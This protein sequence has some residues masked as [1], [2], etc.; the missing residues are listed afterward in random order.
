MNFKRDGWAPSTWARYPDRKLPSIICVPLSL[1]LL[2]GRSIQPMLRC[3]ELYSLEL[4]YTPAINSISFA[5]LLLQE[6]LAP[7]RRSLRW[8]LVMKGKS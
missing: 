6:L 3:E 8:A 2:S 1:A 5:Q 4:L 7:N